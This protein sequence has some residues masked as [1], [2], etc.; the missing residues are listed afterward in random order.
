MMI[1]SRLVR[2]AVAILL[3]D[4]CLVAASV[5]ALPIHALA[6]PVPRQT[7]GTT[8]IYLPLVIRGYFARDF[9][10]LG[11]PD[12][13]AVVGEPYTGQVKVVSYDP[14]L[15]SVV[16]FRLAEIGAPGSTAPGISG[17]GAITW[18]P[19]QA[20]LGTHRLV[21]TAVLSD[22]STMDKEIAIEVAPRTLLI[23]A[24]VGTEGGLLQTSNGDYRIII[25]PDAVADDANHVT[26]ELSVVK[27]ADGN[28]QL[29]RAFTGLK[30][31]VT[32]TLTVPLYAAALADAAALGSAASVTADACQGLD[33]IAAFN[34][35]PVKWQGGFV[36]KFSAP[37][38]AE[39]II[40]QNVSA[41]RLS[42]SATVT[43]YKA[44][45]D[46]GM[47][48]L[49]GAC[50]DQKGC[51]GKQPVLFVHGYNTF[52]QLSGGVETWGCAFDYVKSLGGM[53]FEF[54][55][56][57]NTRFEDVAYYLSQAIAHVSQLTG[58]KPLVVVHSMGGLLST[59]YLAG[60]AQAPDATGQSYKAVGYDS[61]EARGGRKSAAVAGLITVSSPLS[62]I[63]SQTEG[64]TYNLPQGRDVHITAKT[65]E[66]CGDFT[67]GESGLSTTELTYPGHN[68]TADTTTDYEQVFGFGLAAPGSLVQK[69][70]TAWRTNGRMPNLHYDVLVS[71]WYVPG[72]PKW[73]DS[74]YGDG[75]IAVTGMQ[76]LPTHF[77]GTGADGKP[78]NYIRTAGRTLT[79][80]EKATA[81]IPANLDYTFMMTTTASAGE[82]G[83][84][85][86]GMF[87]DYAWY[88]WKPLRPLWRNP[89]PNAP[90]AIFPKGGKLDYY[91]TFDHALKPV[92]DRAYAQA[93]AQAPVF[94]DLPPVPLIVTGSARQMTMLDTVT[95]P[96][97]GAPVLVAFY[98]QGVYVSALTS[99][100]DAA[101][102]FSLDVGRVLDDY[103]IAD[104]SDVSLEARI[105]NDTTHH[106]T[107][108]K[109]GIGEVA[110]VTDL[111]AI[112]LG[113]R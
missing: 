93:A 19:T 95:A 88:W 29:T 26:V 38:K 103:G 105:G 58:R 12:D 97:S 23:A 92:L 82:F 33:F 71:T 49:R 73:Q 18:T 109:V 86:G 8:S 75:L 94:T 46:L 74:D 34:P 22:T 91:G 17:H 54:R 53:P 55:W 100:T 56:R 48:E 6:P 10:V 90:A 7:D 85:H 44:Q 112:E 37:A 24:D 16:D 36:W 87:N 4:L 107:T 15:A 83:Y 32:P 39:H 3:A 57:A 52:G 51:L 67:C 1:P 99:V 27:R 64:M 42:G 98:H 108:A 79:A 78:Y 60:L 113:L 31:G 59:T 102:A 11:A 111:G 41:V 9:I 21:V 47:T 13:L 20:D 104:L 43:P 40:S 76:V 61:A 5:R 25:P 14:S 81:G 69:L 84:P 35:D 80:Q 96:L 45:P 65:I 62:G 77:V 63:A 66:L 50:N 70:Y 68:T 110:A 101:G 106:A 72:T 30:P 89:N 2:Y 28:V